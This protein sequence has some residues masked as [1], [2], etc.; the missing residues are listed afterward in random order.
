M[1]LSRRKLNIPLR[2]SNVGS[3]FRI[4]AKKGIKDVLV[5]SDEMFDIRTYLFRNGFDP[6][7]DELCGVKLHLQE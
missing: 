3:V 5:D 4:I 7:E 1:K 6:Y 2:V